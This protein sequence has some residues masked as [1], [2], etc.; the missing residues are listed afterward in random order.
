MTNE[1]IEILEHQILND[2]QKERLSSIDISLPNNNDKP[3]YLGL[4]SFGNVG[5]YIG[6]KWI[7]ENEIAIVVNPKV[8]DLDY[9][10]MFMHCFNNPITSKNISK[11]YDIDFEKT[12][13]QIPSTSFELTPLIIIHFLNLVRKIVKKGLKRNYIWV[14]SNLNSK[15]KGKILI[16]QNI[17]HNIIK[18]RPERTYCKYQEYSQN[19]LENKLI[20]KTLDFVF[21]YLKTHYRNSKELLNLFYYNYTAFSNIS[22]DVDI[23]E[24][25]NIK[26][27]S[28][29]KEY[30]ETL[31]IAKII[32]RRFDYSI[33]NT[34]KNKENYPPFYIDMSLLFE[35]YIY[36]KLFKVF[37]NDIKFQVNGEYGNVDFLNIQDKTIID[38][39]YKTYYNEN[40]TGQTQWKRDNIAK[41]IRQL[42]GYSRDKKI[43]NKLN[44]DVTESDV[45]IDC[46]IIY[47][48]Q[49]TE[50]ENIEVENFKQEDGRIR[51]FN[52]F[53]KYGIRLPEKQRNANKGYT[54]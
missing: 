54:Q 34:E 26:T 6:A 2:E 51:Q 16:N 3:D 42:S 30:N 11:I 20:K 45:I 9:L 33:R 48:N 35:R 4:S 27:N 46:V 32:L 15:I 38:T 37:G 29:Y 14:E 49:S 39:K 22:S 44:I 40:F 36:S 47:P 23:N 24:I 19:C 43:L 1:L 8:K 50:N 10:Q 5:Y 52:K 21:T 13:I 18:S 25:K 41:D 17:K 12:P 31:R 28:L 7:K 53:Y